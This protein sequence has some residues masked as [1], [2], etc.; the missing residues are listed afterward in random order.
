MIRLHVAVPLAPGAVITLGREQAHYL[1]TVMRAGAGDPVLLFNGRDGEWRARVETLAKSAATLA[2]EAQTRPQAPEPD[3][4]LLAAPLRKERIDLVAEKAAELGASV[5]WPVFTRRTVASRVNA[6]RLAAHL[7][8]ASEQCERLTVPELREPTPL[9]RALA[10]W[11]G[12]RL[13]LW[14]DDRGGRPVKDVLA[15]VAPGTRLALLVGP[16]GGLAPEERDRLA[17][18]PFVRPISLGPRVLRAE[19]AAIAALAVVQ[20]LAGDWADAAAAPAV[21]H[22]SAFLAARSA[23]LRSLGSRMALR[24]RTDFGVTSTSSSSWM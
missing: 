10:G 14:C 24:S 15:A 5:L 3:L 17:A 6:G 19:T 2:C 11:D 18:L 16:E 4:W 7:I 22:D 23:F 9:D 21:N 1:G 13:L 8:E 12:S 20:A